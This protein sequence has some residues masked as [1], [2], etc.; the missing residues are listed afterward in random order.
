MAKKKWSEDVVVQKLAQ[1]LVYGVVVSLVPFLFGFFQAVDRNEHFTFSLIFGAGQLLL[2]CVAITAPA[3]GELVPIEVESRRRIMKTFAIG[4][5]TLVVIISSLWFG[6]ISAT[7]QG[8]SPADPRTISFGSAMVYV[9]ALA[10]SASCLLL[11]AEKRERTG[12]GAGEPTPQK[13]LLD[14]QQDEEE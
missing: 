10:S 1:W 2:V 6:D 3:L 14:I 8:N 5:C 11:A 9:W 12:V 7:I 13:S 4:S